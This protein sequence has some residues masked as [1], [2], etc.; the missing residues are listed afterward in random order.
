MKNVIG[1]FLTMIMAVSVCAAVHAEGTWEAM[2]GLDFPEAGF[3]FVPPDL[4]RRASGVVALDGCYEILDNVWYTGWFYCAMTREEWNAYLDD[5]DPEAPAESRIIPLFSV[6]TLGG[7]MTFRSFNALNGNAIPEE[8]IREVGKAG[9]RTHYLYMEGL[10]PS[11]LDAI[12]PAYREEYTALADS[13]DA[14]AAG[15]TFIEPVKKEDPYA[16]LIGARLEFTAVDLDGNP[17]SSAELFAGNEITMVNIWATWC[18]PCIEELPALGKLHAR[19][20]ER[21]CGVIGMLTDDNPDA[22]RR[23]IADNG[24]GYPVIPAPDSL[25]DFIALEYIPTTLFVGRDGTVL[26]APVVGAHPDEYEAVLDTLLGD[27]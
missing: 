18:G 14:V 13:A 17:V 24:V 21:G 20:R 7:G 12:D 27:Q 15:L 19:L 9:D 6:L 23:L 4:F 22:A 26:A 3:S 25:Y 11:F 8:Y 2:D 5:H 1:L 10:N 16:H